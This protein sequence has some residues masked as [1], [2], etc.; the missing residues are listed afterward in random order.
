MARTWTL[1]FKAPCAWLTANKVYSTYSTYKRAELVRT[2]R[3]ATKQYATQARLPQ[4]LRRVRIDIMA[5][6]QGA[7]P[8]RDTRNLEPTIK[9]VID[10]LGPQRVRT[11]Q[12]VRHVSPGY[13]LVPDDSD[14]YVVMGET[15]IGPKLATLPRMHPGLLTITITELEEASGS[16]RG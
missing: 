8:V 4:G 7:G 1:E 6:F 14:R 16:D 3:A 13:G 10:G 9:A 5:R 12:G 15:V 2:W 11:V